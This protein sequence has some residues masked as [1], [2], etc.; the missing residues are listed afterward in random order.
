LIKGDVVRK[1]G[2]LDEK[3]FAYYEDC[4]YSIRV[5]RAGY[6]CALEKN[7]KI[8]HKN[9]GS[10]GF[11]SPLQLF[12][13]TRNLYFVWTNYLGGLE[14]INYLRKYAAEVILTTAFL[15]KKG[16]N[17]SV[18]AC[19]NGAWAGLWGMGGDWNRGIRMPWG[20]RI[21]IL[22]LAS[23]HP[24]MWNRLMKGEVKAVRSELIRRARGKIL[25]TPVKQ[26]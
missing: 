12:L 20:L 3:Y 23:W 17:E 24:H 7:A 10:S 16:L 1:V 26:G 8:Y 5:G 21:L 11:M 22:W 13:R 18:E 6:R 9:S 2:L 25:Q 4:D 14:K 19:L 15:K